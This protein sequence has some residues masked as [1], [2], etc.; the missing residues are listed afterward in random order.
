VAE[1]EAEA[2]SQAKAAA[3]AAKQQGKKPQQIGPDGQPMPKKRG[4]PPK[5][6]P[7]PAAAGAAPAA[8]DGTVVAAAPATAAAPRPRGRPPKAAKAAA[9]GGARLGPVPVR[10]PFVPPP[11]ERLGAQD[12][13]PSA[14][15]IASM[16]VADLRSC[17]S[18]HH[19]CV[20]LFTGACVQCLCA[21]CPRSNVFAI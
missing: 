6:K 12:E 14:E 5:P 4:R 9:A 20:Q 10:D 16:P 11:E 15:A 8:A 19:R 21:C 18:V 1:K 17:A 2:K 3:K 13:M 7:A